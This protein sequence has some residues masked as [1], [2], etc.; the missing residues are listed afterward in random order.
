MDPKFWFAYGGERS[1]RFE[2]MRNKDGTAKTEC[3]IHNS[4]SISTDNKEQEQVQQ[5][6]QQPQQQQQQQQQQS[7]V[8]AEGST[9]S[10]TAVEKSACEGCFSVADDVDDVVVVASDEN[11]VSFQQE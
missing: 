11:A 8:S 2:N 1:G 4:I 10:T 6:L 7:F 9:S 3:G 5:Q